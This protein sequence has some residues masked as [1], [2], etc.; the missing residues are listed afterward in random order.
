M[1]L[2]WCGDPVVGISSVNCLTVYAAQDLEKNIE[3]YGAVSFA[4]Q[5]CTVLGTALL[6]RVMISPEMGILSYNALRGFF[7]TRD[8]F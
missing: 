3:G 8:S 5:F 1:E 6:M 2:I 4:L 7:F